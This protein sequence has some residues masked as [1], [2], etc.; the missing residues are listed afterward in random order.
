ME[1]RI[2]WKA[3]AQARKLGIPAAELD[4][5]APRLEALEQAFRPLS[6]QLMPDQ[7][8][9]AAFHADPESE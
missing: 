1:T 3:I 9:A 4:L 5:I 2:D 7:E 8:P 6:R